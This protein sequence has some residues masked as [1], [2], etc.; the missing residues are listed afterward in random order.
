MSEQLSL[1]L[2]ARQTRINQFLSD[3]LSQLPDAAPALKAAMLHGVLLGGKRL[4]PMLVYATGEMLGVSLAQLDRAAAALEMVHAYSLIHDDLP[5]MDDDALRRGQPTCHVAFDEATAILAGDALQT[6][7]FS[8]LSDTAFASSAQVQLQLIKLLADAS[9]LRGMCAG[10]A[11]DMA[12]TNQ[13]ITL[14]QLQ[15]VHRHKTGALICT[16]VAMGA[17]LGNAP[18]DVHHQLQRYAEAIGL[19]FQVHDDVLD[20]ISDTD[21]L[22]KPQGSDRHHNKSTYPALM[23]LAGAQQEAQRLIEEALEALSAI[24]YNSDIL[25]ALAHFIVA[26]KN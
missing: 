20:E 19:A 9:G 23:G 25:T 13:Q 17:T 3:H 4:R 5:A 16:A 10:Q 14:S 11:M 12:A 15:Q 26:R 1:F 24:P 8:L 22:G 21:T 7:A 2:S 18:A 6:E